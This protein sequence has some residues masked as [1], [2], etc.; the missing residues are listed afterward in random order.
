MRYK[1]KKFDEKAF[2]ES[3]PDIYEE[4]CEERE[5]DMGIRFYERKK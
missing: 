5:R 2:R 3:H 1:S 4:F